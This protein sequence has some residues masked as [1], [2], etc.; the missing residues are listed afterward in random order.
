MEFVVVDTPLLT[1]FM[2]ISCPVYS[3][4]N[5]KVLP[6]LKSKEALMYINANPEL[7]IYLNKKDINK[8][9]DD[10]KE[11]LS[12]NPLWKTKDTTEDFEG[13]HTFFVDEVIEKEDYDALLD[14]YKY[15]YYYI[16]NDLKLVTE[17]NRIRYFSHFQY[18][19]SITLHFLMKVIADESRISENLK[20]IFYLASYVHDIGMPEVLIEEKQIDASS[21]SYDNDTI[22]QIITHPDES[23]R[24]VDQVVK[25]PSILNDIILNHHEYMNG[26]GYPKGLKLENQVCE[27]QLFAIA[28]RWLTKAVNM[29]SGKELQPYHMINTW[30]EKWEKLKCFPYLDIL[31]NY[32][33]ARMI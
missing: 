33:S 15:I 27:V 9:K 21:D 12:F 19:H 1:H 24:L 13:F 2:E 18:I 14:D 5:E 28:H 4:Q 26:D 17:Y 8:V 32:F 3:L 29:A 16:N 10:V 23:V 31:Y 25:L 11:R 7:K 22:E 20:G 30:D 6:L